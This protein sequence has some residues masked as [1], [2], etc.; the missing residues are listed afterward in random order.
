MSWNFSTG[1]EQL[2]RIEK[3]KYDYINYKA[4]VNEARRQLEEKIRTAYTEM[5]TSSHQY[6][7][8]SR[9]KG[10]QEALL[11]IYKN[12]FEGG[13]VTLLQL[14]QSENQ[15]FSAGLEKIG[16]KYRLLAA[17]YNVLASMGELQK[18]LNVVPASYDTSKNRQRPRTSEVSSNSK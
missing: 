2:N 9:R 5:E 6:D 12:Q 1:G 8:Q 4:R 18:A 16:A 11:K 10:L 15:L 7:V 14:L 3:K 13:S 17:R